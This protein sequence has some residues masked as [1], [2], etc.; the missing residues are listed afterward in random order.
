M[1]FSVTTEHLKHFYQEGYLELEEL[2]SEGE[3]STLVKEIGLA[4][5]KAPG[6]PPTQFYRSIP[7]ITKLAKKRGWGEIAAGLIKQKPL[8]LLSDTFFSASPSLPTALDSTECGVLVNLT[9]R[10]GIFFQKNSDKIP[11][12]KGEEGCYLFLVLTAQRLT[13]AL[14]PLV[15]R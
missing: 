5:Q 14:N 3:A 12:Y 15:F 8:R 7:L 11:L 9:R 13:D 2:L 6:Y 4:L 1:R 10:T